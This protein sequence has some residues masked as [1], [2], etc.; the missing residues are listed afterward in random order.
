M[1]DKIAP[2]AAGAAS[3]W[4]IDQYY[5]EVQNILKRNS[6]SS[7]VLIVMIDGDR[8]TLTERFDELRQKYAKE[9]DDPVHVFVPCR[10]IESWFEFLEQ[11]T[12]DLT[13]E[14]ERDY[15][16]RY[17][18][19]KPSEYAKK[20][21][22]KVKTNPKDKNQWPRSLLAACEEWQRIIG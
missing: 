20:L 12:L 21:A 3:R 10:N 4:V 7:T 14:F 6:H 18:Q 11:G 5:N 2:P 13:T 1:I 15:K 19:A 16:Q 8:K 22:R 17:R 9:N